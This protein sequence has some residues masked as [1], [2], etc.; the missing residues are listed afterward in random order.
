MAHSLGQDC[1]WTVIIII[2]YS[3][4]NF[5]YP[6]L[7]TRVSPPTHSTLNTLDQNWCVSNLHLFLAQ[8]A[9]IN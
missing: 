3:L 7:L 9:H 5:F 2:V 6:I 4:G 8:A 1:Q